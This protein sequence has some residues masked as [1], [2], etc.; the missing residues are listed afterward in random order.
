MLRENAIEN[1]PSSTGEILYIVTAIAK[2]TT[3]NFKFKILL[4]L[5]FVKA[6]SVNA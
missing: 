3:D 4:K 6:R 2:L 1:A 5:C